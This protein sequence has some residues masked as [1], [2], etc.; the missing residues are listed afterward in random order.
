[1]SIKMDKTKYIGYA[2]RIRSK[3][4]IKLLKTL[5]RFELVKFYVRPHDPRTRNGSS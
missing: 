3:S 5:S 2:Y 4:Q 1:M